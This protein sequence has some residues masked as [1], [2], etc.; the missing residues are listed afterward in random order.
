[1]NAVV[2]VS[3]DSR[4]YLCLRMCSCV[5]TDVCNMLCDAQ[6]TMHWADDGLFF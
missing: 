1:M 2:G 5:L 3:E 6:A 4:Q